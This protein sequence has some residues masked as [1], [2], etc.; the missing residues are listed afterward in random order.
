MHNSLRKYSYFNTCIWSVSNI[1]LH[2]V[3][4]GEGGTMRLKIN[5]VYILNNKSTFFNFSNRK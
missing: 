2:K 1:D 5:A 4:D 3:D